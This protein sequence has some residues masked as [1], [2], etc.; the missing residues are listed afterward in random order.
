LV[1]S[2]ARWKS[3]PSV[4]FVHLD[5]GAAVGLGLA[6]QGQ[7]VGALRDHDLGDE[8]R[9]EARLV[10][11]L[12]WRVGGDDGLPAAT[13]ELLLDVQ[14]PLHA[15]GHEVVEL[16]DVTSAKP[17]EVVT[18]AP[19]AGLLVL[20]DLVLDLAGD[21]LALLLRVLAPLLKG[22]DSGGLRSDRIADGLDHRR[23]LL[24][25]LAEGVALQ[26]LDGG[27]HGGELLAQ[28]R[29]RLALLLDDRGLLGDGGLGHTELRRQVFGLVAPLTAV[30]AAP[31]RPVS[32]HVGGAL[33]MG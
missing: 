9:A 12:G 15:R 30:L 20:A 29:Q 23:H 19:G 4:E 33:A 14:L 18:A 8:G 26:P 6:I 3:W 25:A 16:G 32:D 10:V 22:R 27:L 28:L 7:R 17:A 13:A 31:H 11:D 2:A 24:G 5:A 21:E 1:A